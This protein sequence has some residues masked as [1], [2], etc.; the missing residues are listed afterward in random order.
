MPLIEKRSV[1][2]GISVKEAMRRQ[3]IRLPQSA[4]IDFC[5]NRMI[6]YKINSVLIINEKQRPTGVVSKT[7]LMGAY[8]AGFPIETPVENI[9]VGP[10][11]FC[12]PDDELE[13]S[14][15]I[16][17]QNGIHRLYV[18]GADASDV[19]GVMA[20]PDIVGLLYRYCRACD[21]GL[22]KARRRQEDDQFRRL[23]VKDVMTATVTA[24]LEEDELAQVIEGLT[25]HRFGAVLINNELGQAVGV[26][27]KSDLI[28]AYK[29]GVA[30]DARADRVMSKPV[31]S[32]DAQ[33]D[34]ADAIQQMLLRDVQ[35][36]FVH[37]DDPGRMVGILSLSDAVRF[38]SGSCRACTASRIIQE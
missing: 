23:K 5:I 11:L 6:K 9:M 17:Q 33:A 26:V 37:A 15:D 3:V 21:R 2:S 4:P 1:L 30:V 36:L 20:Y 22:L 14:L 24:Y 31:V 29:H 38:R 13:L 8:Y 32:Y 28:V 7:D 18:Q 12:Y 16:M 34:L 35:R 25:A 27:S 10:P 19:V